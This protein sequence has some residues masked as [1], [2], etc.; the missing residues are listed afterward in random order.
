M[1]DANVLSE[2]KVSLRLGHIVFFQV[3]RRKPIIAWKEQLWFAD[4]TRELKRFLI[5][6]PGQVR[7]AV[8]LMDLVRGR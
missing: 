5:I 3:Q 4:F 6:V 7:F 8:T 1:P 2:R